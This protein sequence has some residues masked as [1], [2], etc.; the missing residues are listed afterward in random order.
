MLI[1]KLLSIGNAGW[2]RETRN[3]YQIL[4]TRSSYKNWSF[5]KEFRSVNFITVVRNKVEWYFF[6]SRTYL[7][8]L[9]AIAMPYF[10]HPSLRNLTCSKF[11][12]KMTVYT[13]IWLKMNRETK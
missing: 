2:R 11:R 3:E 10:C 1:K 9:A 5:G 7:L 6:L 8:L 4:V 12:N 13:L